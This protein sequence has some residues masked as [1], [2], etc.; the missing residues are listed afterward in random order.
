M[1]I[2]TTPSTPATAARIR[3]RADAGIVGAAACR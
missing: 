1:D 2:R 3:G